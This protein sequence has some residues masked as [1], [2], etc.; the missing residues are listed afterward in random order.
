MKTLIITEKPSVA[1]DFA[2]ALGVNGK[3]DGYIE[4]GSYTI[5]WAVGHLVE[6]MAPDEYDPK[7][8][9]WRME[10][11][12]IIP[13]T[14]EYKPLPK[15]RKQLNVI[16]GLLK[17]GSLETVVIATDAGR[18]GEVIARTILMAS[19]FGEMGRVQRFWTSQ[20]LTPQ[21]V[22]DG[23][24]ALRP[25]SDYDRLWQAGQARQ[26]ADWLVGMT[27][28]RAATLV[29]R[30]KT[31]NGKNRGRK[32]AN[33]FSVGRVQTAVLSLIADRRREREDFKP[34]PY[35]VLRAVFI[36][37]K[38]EWAGMWF[39]KE[40]TRF[41][42]ETE[43]KE[44]EAKMSGQTG[45]VRSVKRQKKKEPPP[46][47]YS[48]TDLQREA[49]RKLG[50]SAKET[51][52]IAQRL[53]EEKKCLSYP[54]TD[55][56]VL[57]SQN[58]DMARKLV[59]KLSG[60]YPKPFAGTDHS[61]IRA[62]NKRVF[63]DARLTDHHALI[64]LAPAPE[65]VSGRDRKVYDLVLK[66]F[67]AAFHP[68]CEFEQTEIIT[69]VRDETF[70]TR[71]KRI[72]IPGWRV[73][74]E[75]DAPRK[76]AARNGDEAVENLPPLIKG[77]PA[78]VKETRLERKMTQ[79][80]P[81][82]NEALLL[83]E[84]TNPGRYVS[85]DDLKKIYRGDVGLG[86]QATRAQIIETL[87]AREYVVRRK[88]LLIATDKGVR[89]I[90]MLRGF[91]QAGML[92]SP[93]ETARWERQLEQIA[94]GN[95]SGEDFLNDIKRVVTTVVDEFK[96]EPEFLGR[97]P[98][99]GGQVIRGKRDF[100]CSNWRKKDGGC[101]FVIRS[102]MAGQTLSHQVISEL[103]AR[104]EAGPLQGFA[105]ENSAPFTGLL[106]L[107]ESDGFWVVRI[108]P[109]DAAAKP[110]A[111]AP[112]G[113]SGDVIGK[114]P[115]CGGEVVDNPKS[116]GCANWRDED[117]GCK[118][119]IWKEVAKKL[120]TPAMAKTL[121]EEGQIGP[122]DR[123]ISKKGKPF[124]ASLKLTQEDEK[125]GVRFLF[126]DRPQEE[127]G[128][129]KV[130]GRCPACGG[131]V[132]D[133]P[134]SYGCVNWR[135]EDGGCKMVIWKTVAQKEISPEVARLLLEKRETDILFGFISRKG[136]AFAARLRLEEDVSG[137]YKVVFDFSDVR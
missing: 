6:L 46:L 74:Y 82:Y 34:E 36:G 105:D 11:L 95:G 127:N 27:C 104:K 25:A 45:A 2:K 15:T 89:L 44:I 81:D 18:E 30:S 59:K 37:E 5:T 3:H 75:A 10:T 8:K 126:D 29:S 116:Y 43:A 109:T 112:T 66:R 7:W 54:R 98:V 32:S 9:R 31:G 131:E 121:I 90:N 129:A 67:A 111:P 86:T 115:A 78:A 65:S 21:V 35:W 101:R 64:P 42:K 80:P 99:C 137:A 62:S 53:Y 97:C 119:V 88:K 1:M 38:G 68:D 71:G 17:R 41:T 69:A 94:Q 133:N 23:M 73:V 51:L 122:L 14:F 72:L 117:G 39:R 58:V 79:P 100:G 96:G 70:R 124:S 49:N 114:C 128:S 48:L 91:R 118:F 13:A 107:A 28:T 106:R 92:A 134:K 33:L 47:L 113:G 26:I 22:R 16:R 24:A 136:S 76:K 12:P 57:G 110:E 20:A 55:S 83:K 123:F 61:L 4:D 63:N 108:E 19:G 103:L 56:K 135:E 87:L 84:M 130:I 77:D 132:V 102:Q 120:I 50:L 93:R 125:W 60:V 40:L 52:G 85:E